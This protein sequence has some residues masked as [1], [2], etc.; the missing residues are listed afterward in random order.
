MTVTHP[1]GFTAA[2]VTAGLKQSG[3]RDLALIVNNGPESAVAA[4]WTANRCK[5]NPVLWSERVVADGSAR[6]IV[7]NSGGAN[8]YTGHAGFQHTHATAERAADVLEV[9]PV[10][11]VVCSTGLIGILNDTST[12]LAGDDAAAAALRDRAA[13]LLRS[14]L[15][16]PDPGRIWWSSPSELFIRFAMAEELLSEAWEVARSHGCSPGSLEALAAAS[17]ESRPQDALNAYAE[18]A[19]ALIRETNRGAYESACRIIRRM[20]DVR[21]RLGETAAH[22]AWLDD[23]ARRYKAKRTFV[24]LLRSQR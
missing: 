17:E 12:L 10:D 15:Q 22:Q 19:E 16:E 1:K 5:A 4:V 20:S 13:A 3:G 8:C 14:R 9:S 24:A 6:V 7:A 18:R 23:L 11:V 21:A 2:G